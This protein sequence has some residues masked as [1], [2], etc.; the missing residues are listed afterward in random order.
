MFKS[1]SF[2]AAMAL[3]AIACAPSF[4][5]ITYLTQSRSASAQGASGGTVASASAPDFA[6][7]NVR[8]N[9]PGGFPDGL[10]SEATAS[11]FSTLA[12]N[13]ILVQCKTSPGGSGGHYGLA[14]STALLTFS[15]PTNS[16]FSIQTT[17]AGA[18]V[19][20]SGPGVNIVR[21]GP[22]LTTITSTGTFQA[23]QTYTL[24]CEPVNEISAGSI[25]GGFA[26]VIVSI[27]TPPSTPVNP[28]TSVAKIC[29]G[30]TTSNLSVTNPGSGLVVDWYLGGCG[31]MPVGTG[32]PITVST[33]GDYYAKTR[34]LSDGL[35]SLACA[36]VSVG[37]YTASNP[38]G[39]SVNRNNLCPHDQGTI[40][41]SI[42]GGSGQFVRWYADS[43]SGAP[44]GEGV[45][46]SIPAP[47]RTTVYYG[48]WVNNCAMS[49]CATVA[50]VVRDC[51]ADIDCNGVVDDSDF[52]LFAVAYD[53][54][55]CSDPAMP[56]DCPSDINQDGFVDDADF[57]AFAAQY[58]RLVCP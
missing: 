16:A 36:S 58:D 18:N 34:R 50:V 32:N 1:G 54:L 14:S 49:D 35:R 52:A 22:F 24:S 11:Q 20:L 2:L 25:R 33:P 8:L 51:A 30:L 43:C 46:I 28:K 56:A 39:A 26:D 57:S 5:D 45:S 17:W 44:I 6:P 48:R 9:S 12:Q 41:L 47:R 29:P 13:Q 37:T 27:G 4:G 21:S 40:Q 53:L 10:G 3:A 31:E 42:V 7:F 55:A 19:S 23:G 38:T 15:V